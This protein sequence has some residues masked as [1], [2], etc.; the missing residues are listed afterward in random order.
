MVMEVKGY[1]GEPGADL[2]GADLT[3]ADLTDAILTGATMPDG[4]IHD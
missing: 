3:G 4:P 2:T 1:R